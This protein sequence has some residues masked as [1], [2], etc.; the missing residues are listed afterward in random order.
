MQY[1]L[2]SVTSKFFFTF[3]IALFVLAHTTNAQV[4]TNIGN[5]ITAQYNTSMANYEWNDAENVGY[6]VLEIQKNGQHYHT[7]ELPGTVTKYQLDFVPELKHDDKIE[8]KITQYCNNGAKS[9]ATNDFIIVVDAIVYLIGDPHNGGTIKVEPV[10]TV[11]DNLVPADKI[12][13]L[14]EPDYFRL[15]SGFYAPFGIAVST[16]SASPIEQLRFEKGDLCHCFEQAI[17]DGILAPN[18]GHGPKYDGTPFTCEITIY[19]FTHEDCSRE[20]RGKERGSSTFATSATPLQVAPNPSTDLAQITFSLHEA[21]MVSVVMYDMMGNAVTTIAHTQQLS[22][23]DYTYPVQIG[24]LPS[25][26][27]FCTLKAQDYINTIKLSVV[28]K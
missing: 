19:S 11:N 15:T 16:T 20:I 10:M 21:S 23:G 6:Y 7:V 3:F 17:A 12:C 25:G 24:D 2:S 8:A 18:G 26:I 9:S 28:G 22:A 4:C 5:F 27:Y 1:L 14:C 13:G